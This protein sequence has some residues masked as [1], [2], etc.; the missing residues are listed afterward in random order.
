MKKMRIKNCCV[1]LLVFAAASLVTLPTTLAATDGE[2]KEAAK[3]R[4]VVAKV[5]GH[6]IYEDQ[7]T[8]D[9]NKSMKK[10]KK[11]G[12]KQ[13]TPALTYKFQTRALN[14]IIDEEL[15]IQAAKKITVAE[16]DKRVEAK[17]QKVKR[18]YKTKEQFEDHLKRKNLTL[19]TLQANLAQQAHID[20]YLKQQ[21][22]TNPEIPEE[23]IREFYDSNPKN[24]ERK[25][26]IKVSHIL[27]KI[28]EDA[29][30]EEK[31]KA[32]LKAEEI[33]KEIIGGKDF[34]EMAKEYSQCNSAS[35]GGSLRYI[36]RGYMPK[37]FDAV[38]FSIEKD[39]ISD[40]VETK[41]GYHIIK[42]TDK[43]PSG[44][45]PYDEVRSLIKKYLQQDE[46]KRMLEEHTAILKKNA[47]IEIFLEDP[48]N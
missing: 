43:K 19:E 9:I 22:I 34:A 7:L 10:W 25:E 4:K 33:R 44:L 32:F 21:G 1:I 23:A 38:A 5:N 26:T 41:F 37:E 45:A 6:Q 3:E 42:V 35:G 31:E 36:E 13:P 39:T 14:K 29:G 24:Y 48:D 30:P 15:I 28:G 40:I 17:L 18:K 8:E 16:L 27:I 20:E 11:Y 46:T 47:T 2:N 12:M